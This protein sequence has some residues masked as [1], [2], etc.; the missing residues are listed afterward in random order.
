[1]AA[2]PAKNVTEFNKLFSEF[3]AGNEWT[4]GNLLLSGLVGKGTFAI[5]VSNC[6]GLITTVFHLMLKIIVPNYR[7]SSIRN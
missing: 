2:V 5:Y 4:L 3:F 6:L 1:M 7:Q